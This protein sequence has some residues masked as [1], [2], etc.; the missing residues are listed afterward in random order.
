MGQESLPI[1]QIDGSWDLALKF[2]DTFDLPAG[3]LLFPRDDDTTS[4]P[5]DEEDDSHHLNNHQTHTLFPRSDSNS[6]T[7]NNNKNSSSSPTPLE[8]Y[9]AISNVVFGIQ[10]AGS[11]TTENQRNYLCNNNNFK[12][13]PIEGLG[14][15]YDKLK[16]VICTDIPASQIPLD[17]KTV[18]DSLQLYNAMLWLQMT[19]NVFF[20]NATKLC[21]M[22]NVQQAEKVGMDAINIMWYLCTVAYPHGRG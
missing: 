1:Q 20:G 2:A 22:F 14:L 9:R 3:L 15:N 7:N 12:M 21:D 13:N 19:F 5:L 10:V 6:S 18:A 16:Q 11:L 17:N 8:T 4:I